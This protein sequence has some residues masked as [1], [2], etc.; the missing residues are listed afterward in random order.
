MKHLIIT[1]LVILSSLI[2]RA[3]NPLVFVKVEKSENLY[4][5]FENQNLVIHYYTDNYIIG[6]LAENA[7]LD[8]ETVILDEKAFWDT[9]GYFIVYCPLNQRQRYLNEVK[10]TGEV[11]FFNDNFLIIKSIDNNRLIP[12]KNDG[13]VYIS[14]KQASLPNRVIDFPVITEI[15]PMIQ[16]LS[17]NI[18]TD[19]IMATIQHLQDYGTRAYDEPQ[20]YQ[21]RNWL[22]AKYEQMGLE[23]EIHNFTIASN[24]S[25][26]W[27]YY[28]HSNTSGNVIAIQTGTLY[29]DEFIVCGSHYDSWSWNPIT[30]AVAPGAD[31]NASGTAG[32]VEIA[33]ILSQYQFERSII[34]CNFTAEEFGL[35]GSAAYATRCKQE[36]K[37]ILGYFNIDMSGYL[38]PGTDIH[39]HLIYPTSAAPLA[40]YYTNV[41]NIYFPEIPIAHF[42][43]LPGG[44][45]DHTSFNQKGYYGIFPFEDKDFDSPYIH[46]A[47]DII[48]LS[49]N[50]P[51]QCR[52]FT[53]ITC[54]SISTLAGIVINDSPIAN[55][56]ADKTE[57][58][59][60]E[61]IS[62]TNV[63]E[64]EPET[65][66]W[67]FEGGTPAESSDENPVIMYETEG[68]YSV[69]LTVKKGELE[70]TKTKQNYITVTPKS[71][72][73]KLDIASKTEIYPNPTSGKLRITNYELRIEKIEIFD[74][75]GRKVFEQ[76]YGLKNEIDIDISHLQSG[77]YFLKVNGQMIK[78]RIKK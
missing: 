73:K 46:S 35:F 31:D 34:Y 39:I 14:N 51:E 37:N 38:K 67:H 25:W 22:I 78:L 7:K 64:N 53:Q 40:N 75:L 43:A 30:A 70:D 9:E 12:A 21:A 15:D 42:A 24:S 63:S 1:S 4:S 59:E 27:N 5:L 44:D 36:N 68:K 23:T 26:G 13:M 11:L 29:P 74:V 28:P 18:K 58:E 50:T 65:F 32:I 16:F 55:F 76:S 2:L 66:I 20:S 41:A 56:Y 69:T 48:G 3:N 17:G 71:N 60:G 54:A 45:S 61:T 77:I 10:N 19:S 72:I 8:N 47:D 62:F 6:S 52:V 57:I 49:V 33:R